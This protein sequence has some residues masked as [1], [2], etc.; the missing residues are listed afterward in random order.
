MIKHGV[1]FVESEDGPYYTVY[2]NGKFVGTEFSLGC[3]NWLFSYYDNK[4][5]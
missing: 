5:K 2:C 4:R 3:A 1:Y